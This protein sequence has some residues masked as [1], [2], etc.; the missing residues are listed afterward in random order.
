MEEKIQQE[1]M[2][3]VGKKSRRCQNKVQNDYN[4]YKTLLSDD[5]SGM[6]FKT[7]TY[8]ELKKLKE[9]LIAYIA[10][11]HEDI[12]QLTYPDYNIVTS[13]VRT[14]LSNIANDSVSK[15]FC[16]FM[17]AF[18]DPALKLVK[19]Q[20]QLFDEAD[21]QKRYVLNKGLLCFADCLRDILPKSDDKNS[22][23]FAV[24]SVLNRLESFFNAKELFLCYESKVD[25]NKRQ[26]IDLKYKD[27]L[28]D[29]F[30][31]NVRLYNGIISN[32]G[33]KFNPKVLLLEDKNEIENLI[34]L[35]GFGKKAVADMEPLISPFLKGVREILSSDNLPD[36]VN[37]PAQ[38]LHRLM[39]EEVK[40]V[41]YEVDETLS[42]ARKFEIAL[43]QAAEY[44]KCQTGKAR[45]YG[46]YF[47][48]FLKDGVSL[49]VISTSKTEER[50]EQILRDFVQ[51]KKIKSTTY[52]DLEFSEKLLSQIKEVVEANMHKPK[53]ALVN[54]LGIERE[55]VFNV[56]SVA[57]SFK[58]EGE[59]NPII[60]TTKKE[61]MDK[62]PV[63]KNLNCL[64]NSLREL[65][66]PASKEIILADVEEKV[67]KDKKKGEFMP[68][69][70]EK[71]LDTNPD[72]EKVGE[73]L[74]QLKREELGKAVL[75]QGRI[76]YEIN[77]WRTKEEIE[78]IYRQ[79]FPGKKERFQATQLSKFE[80]KV[81]PTMGF[82][83]LGKTGKWRFTEDKTVYKNNLIE[84]LENF[85]KKKELVTFD[86][87]MDL[88]KEKDLPYKQDT[89]RGYLQG[90]CYVDETGTVFVL[91]DKKDEHPE[92]SWKRKYRGDSTNWTVNRAVEILQSQPNHKMAYQQFRDALLRSA[93]EEGYRDAVVYIITS[94]AGDD[95]LFIKQDG[96]IELNMD[97]LE[98]T[99][100]KFEGLYRK[101]PHFM[102]IF[103]YT[104]NAL[105]H[106]ENGQLAL[107]ELIKRISGQTDISISADAVRH[108]FDPGEILPD[109]LERFS[110]E[111]SVYIRLVNAVAND[112]DEQYKVDNTAPI[113]DEE[114]PALVVDTKERPVVTY[115]T[116]FKWDELR[117]I[118]KRELA[119]YDRWDAD[120][121][122][123]SDASLDKFQRFMEESTNS[124]LSDMI[125][126]DM[127][128]NWF[129]NINRFAKYHY[130][131]DLALNFEALLKDIVRRKGKEVTGKGLAEVCHEY[132][133]EY[134]NVI[135][136]RDTQ[137]NGYNKIFKS[138]HSYRNQ[139]SHG[140]GRP[141]E[142]IS[143]HMSS[144]I[145]AY[146]ALY[147]RTVVKY[148][149]G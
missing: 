90:M 47:E 2:R 69:Y 122:I 63:G 29:C 72:I 13:A 10:T 38:W 41:P 78:Q 44:L 31:S 5:L 97:V 53:E 130:F 131:T 99:D 26:H 24:H 108:A 114:A 116:V 52:K 117:E 32:Y 55:Q 134:Y 149:K 112:E 58:T 129:A 133:P 15:D 42:L 45:E 138:L 23:T 25:E 39:N 79:Q 124:N 119:Y 144:S 36:L 140:D 67:R 57:F 64:K 21:I 83:N 46:K 82:I 118:M 96:F 125:P 147:V 62:G 4:N 80:S 73:N 95:K 37:D 100:L 70:I 137:L 102:D 146:I 40:T 126:Q 66:F 111:R 142:M 141:V 81:S 75:I 104:F 54:A 94:Y 49:E 22:M 48:S 121:S 65:L 12:D 148:Y 11:V 20:E 91:S 8:D 61:Q 139:I 89:I 34:N 136:N 127:Y 27:F 92:Y 17:S 3:L 88:I 107:T 105:S 1:Y 135:D 106:E 51:R 103:S 7:R 143:I 14:A 71:A 16:E 120:N 132:Y 101:E 43:E 86:E 56:L 93:R 18:E 76:M 60:M 35:N 113:T 6:N 77:D 123:I 84:L 98:K 109:G 87:V 28:N 110:V 128:E 33:E 85:L 30:N 59:E 115:Q 145:L 50:Y 68:D 74:Y 19:K 9:E